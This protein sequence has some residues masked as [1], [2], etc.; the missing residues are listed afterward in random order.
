MVNNVTFCIQTLPHD[1]SGFSLPSPDS[2]VL[3][4]V[5]DEHNWLHPEDP[6]AAMLT[7]SCANIFQ[8]GEQLIPVGS[9]EFV[10]SGLRRWYGIERGL[11]PLFIPEQLRPFANRWVQAAHGKR[12]VESAIANLGKAFIKSASA[13]KCDYAGIYHAGQKLPDD[14]DYFVSQT[15]DIVS[16]WRIFVHRG[17]ILDLK[18]YSGDP[19]QMPD[20]TT[21]EKM[22]EAFTN[23]PKAYTLD[24]AVLRN[25]QTAVIEVHNFIACGLYGFTSPKLPLM[26]CDGIYFELE[27]KM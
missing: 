17:N 18:N 12:Q 16:E 11:T 21:V 23:T 5:I 22:V 20:R 27:Q 13:V 15:I 24:V 19:W 14:T 9:I 4:E 7:S 10:E 1:N 2:A 3:L 26:Y 25:G 6:I 8:D